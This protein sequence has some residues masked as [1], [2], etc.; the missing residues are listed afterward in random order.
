[1]TDLET[2]MEALGSDPRPADNQPDYPCLPNAAPGRIHRCASVHLTRVV[3]TAI[4][5]AAALHAVTPAFG[6]GCQCKAETFL[7]SLRQF[8]LRRAIYGD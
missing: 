4:C 8:G 2:V 7:I 3:H 5:A 6:R 1:M